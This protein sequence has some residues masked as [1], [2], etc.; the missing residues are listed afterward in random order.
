MRSLSRRLALCV[1]VIVL[2]GCAETASWSG[3]GDESRLETPRNAD[4]YRRK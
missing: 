2:A 4:P 1:M 3:S